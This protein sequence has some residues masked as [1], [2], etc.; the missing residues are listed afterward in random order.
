M[1][2]ITQ[3]ADANNVR[4]QTAVILVKLYDVVE[5]VALPCFG[6]EGGG[7]GLKW[8]DRPFQAIFSLFTN[9]ATQYNGSK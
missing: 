4:T 9:S 7:E 1:H 6:E 2:F 3:H 5:Q 8:E